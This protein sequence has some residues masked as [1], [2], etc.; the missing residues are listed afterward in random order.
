MPQI[1]NDE[2]INKAKSVIKSRK[3]KHGYL[4]G[5]SDVH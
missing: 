4:V 2:L 1:T 3:I 5:M